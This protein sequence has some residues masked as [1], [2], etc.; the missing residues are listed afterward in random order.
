MRSRWG[1]GA[2]RVGEMRM[3]EHRRGFRAERVRLI[4]VEC[5]VGRMF[6]NRVRHAAAAVHRAVAE[7]AA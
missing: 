4:G 7:S 2:P 1:V 6:L 5:L 3:A